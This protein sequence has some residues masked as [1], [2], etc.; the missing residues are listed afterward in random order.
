[1]NLLKVVMNQMMGNGIIDFEEMMNLYLLM[2]TVDCFLVPIYWLWSTRQ[3]FPE[4]WSHDKSNDKETTDFYHLH[5][6]ELVPRRPFLNNDSVKVFTD[7]LAKHPTEGKDEENLKIKVEFTKSYSSQD[8]P[9]ID[10]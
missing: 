9:T 7:E 2:L 3:S 8:L 1:M 4:L 10:V 6:L 5:S